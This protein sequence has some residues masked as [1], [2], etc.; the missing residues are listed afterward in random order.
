MLR[1]G[2]GTR[3]RPTLAGKPDEFVGRISRD[4]GMERG[5]NMWIISDNLLKGQQDTPHKSKKR[6]NRLNY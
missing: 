4:P 6:I 5:L 3:W 1:P 2:S